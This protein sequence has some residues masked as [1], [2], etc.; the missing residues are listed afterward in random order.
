MCSMLSLSSNFFRVCSTFPFCRSHKTSEENW[1]LTLG[2]SFQIAIAMLLPSLQYARD[3]TYFPPLMMPSAFTMVGPFRA[4]GSDAGA[5]FGTGS[6]RVGV[7]SGSCASAGS[8]GLGSAHTPEMSAP[9][10]SRPTT[11]S[12]ATPFSLVRNMAFKPPLMSDATFSETTLVMTPPARA[13]RAAWLK[14]CA[15]VAGTAAW[16]VCESNVTPTRAKESGTPRLASWRRSN[17]RPFSNLL[18][19]VERGKPRRHAASS[20]VLPSRQQ[21]MSGERIFSVRRF[22]SSSRTC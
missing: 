7:F 16:L 15:R 18:I 22:S 8:A 5:P 4:A 20:R 19:T 14:A 11:T 6:P 13:W 3:R 17:S 10:A 9:A 1:A 12:G 21:R 2:R